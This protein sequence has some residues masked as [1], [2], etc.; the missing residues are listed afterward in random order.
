MVGQVALSLQHSSATDKDT[1][2]YPYLL[3]NGD[4]LF[5]GYE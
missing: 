4:S 3:I 1:P 2:M 5:L